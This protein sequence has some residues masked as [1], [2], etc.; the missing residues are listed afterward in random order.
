[1]EFMEKKMLND[2]ELGN[3]V[4]GCQ[5]M[6]SGNGY[7]VSGDYPRWTV[8]ELLRISYRDAS[9]NIVRAKCTVTSVSSTRNGGQS[10]MEYTYSVLIVW[11]PASCAAAGDV[12]RT[13]YNV[14]ESSLYT[15]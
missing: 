6:S 15:D 13:Y 3:V 14:A 7:C 9:G 8:G 5:I 11:L 1:M 4:G 2:E 12:G 10:G